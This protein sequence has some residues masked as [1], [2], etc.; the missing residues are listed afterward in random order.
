VLKNKIV[1]TCAKG[2]SS[3]LGEEI[4]GLGFPILS[5]EISSVETEGSFEDTLKLNLFLRTG[6][7]V[8]FL[9]LNLA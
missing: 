5:E 6:Q 8:L 7:R 9:L 3:Y 2:I 1:I 4:L